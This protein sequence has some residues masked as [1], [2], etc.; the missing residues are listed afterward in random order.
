[1][2]VQATRKPGK[3]PGFGGII[4]R[5]LHH[6]HGPVVLYIAIFRYRK[7]GVFGQVTGQKH[8]TRVIPFRN[9]PRRKKV[10]TTENDTSNTKMGM[11]KIY[12]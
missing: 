12:V 3:N 10:S 2:E 1:M 8:K 4:A 5:G 11:M 7:M 6:M 9:C